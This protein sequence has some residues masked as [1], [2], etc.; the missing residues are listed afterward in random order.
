ME[1]LLP[2]VVPRAESFAEL[3]RPL[4]NV[5]TLVRP[6]VLSLFFVFLFFFLFFTTE[7][8]TPRFSSQP[9]I[10]QRAGIRSTTILR[11]D[12]GTLFLSYVA[13]KTT[14]ERGRSFVAWA[15]VRNCKPFPSTFADCSRHL[16]PRAKQSNTDELS[17]PLSFGRGRDNCQTF[18]FSF[19][20]HGRETRSQDP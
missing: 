5:H 15:V 2:F 4:T 9:A 20:C 17:F 7:R 13:Q 12:S 18:P 11:P 3:R 6:F 8:R 16:R 10:Y 1:S 14:N 19:C